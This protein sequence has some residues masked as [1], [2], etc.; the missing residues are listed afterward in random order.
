MSATLGV[1]FAAGVIAAVAVAI[2]L[3]L[4]PALGL[5]SHAN[6]R[7]SHTQ[8][9]PTGG[10][11]GIVLAV[12]LVGGYLCLFTPQ[13]ALPLVL[14][15]LI[16]AVG[17]ADDIS[18]VAAQWRL[19]AQA[20]AVGTIMLTLAGPQ[21][22]GSIGPI[23]LLIVMLVL[24]GAGMWWINLYNFLDGID[25]YAACQGIFM[26][27]AA[28][29]L[30][31]WDG[32]LIQHPLIALLAMTAAAIAGFLLFNW[33]PAKIFMGDVGS[34]F[35]GFWL[36]CLMLLTILA[37][38]LSAWQWLILAGLFIADASVTLIVRLRL[39]AS[40]TEAHKNHAYQKLSRRWG[41]HPRVVLSAI[42]AN[43]LIVLPA[44]FFAGLWPD[45]APVL[46]LGVY[47]VLAGATFF[48]RAGHPD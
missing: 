8:A 42:A 24:L 21:L 33:A 12:A 6:H 39:G 44:A 38:W 13:F 40:P 37:G 31:L 22:A 9:T 34:T 46:T 18:P 35:L 20:I 41:G 27:G 23:G 19:L 36:W 3:R 17:L 2:V 7:S 48:T 32:A 47:L 5:V 28:L 30:S 26:V 1:A 11:I 14:A 10:G 16:G 45:F 15:V 4:A 43:L 29:G 25:G